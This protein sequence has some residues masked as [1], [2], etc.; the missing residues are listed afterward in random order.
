MTRKTVVINPGNIRGEGSR[1][2][3]FEDGWTHSV[4]ATACGSSWDY[5]RDRKIC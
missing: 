4:A 5:P 1:P 2:R 3:E